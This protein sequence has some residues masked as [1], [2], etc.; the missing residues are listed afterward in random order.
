MI[1]SKTILIHSAIGALNVV[2]GKLSIPARR[3]DSKQNRKMISP[4]NLF[5]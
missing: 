4:L 2:E 5:L 1:S 3:H